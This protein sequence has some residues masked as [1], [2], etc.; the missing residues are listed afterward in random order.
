MF[1]PK[2]GLLYVLLY[3]ITLS[4]KFLWQRLIIINRLSSR[5]DR[6]LFRWPITR[7]LHSIP[8]CCIIIFLRLKKFLLRSLLFLKIS[9]H[10]TLQ[11]VHAP[12]NENSSALATGFR[13]DNKHDRWVGQAL[14]LGHNSSTDFFISFLVLSLVVLNDFVQITWIQPRVWEEIILLLELF[15]ELAQVHPESVLSSDV[16]HS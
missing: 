6:L 11:L 1:F 14:L 5:I 15:P 8:L 16:V 12:R 10:S 9:L 2:R 13:L 4:L 3:H 7:L